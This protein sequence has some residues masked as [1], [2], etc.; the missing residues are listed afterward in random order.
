MS[1]AYCAPKSTTRTRSWSVTVLVTG[2][3]A[4]EA[5]R[6]EPSPSL[7]TGPV[8]AI[9]PHQPGRS[10]TTLLAHG[11]NP[12]RAVSASGTVASSGPASASRISTR[13]H[14]MTIEFAAATGRAHSFQRRT[15]VRV[16]LPGDPGYDAARMPWN[17]AVDQRPAAVAYP[18]TA[19]EVSEVVRAAAGRRPA[20]RARRAPATTPAR[21][22]RSSD[23]VL[24]RTSA[25]TGVARSTPSAGSPA[26]RP[27]CSG[28][29]SSRRPPPHGL[30]ALHGSSPDVGVVGYSLGG[31]IGWYARQLGMAT[32]SVTAVELV[33]GDGTQVRADARH[34]PRPVLGGPRRRRQLRR[35]HRDGVPA[36]RHRDGVR[37]DA[38]VGPGARREGAA[39]LGRVDRRPRRTASPRRSGC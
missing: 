2:P 25:M 33:L 13:R 12:G 22:A 29:T 20:G 19:D 34:Q 35:R 38:A 16:H 9:H 15:T 4:E 21:S 36:L 8:P 24:L 6:G 11:K 1:W 23:V 3:F 26:S 17:V 28:S 37:R 14:V 27:A 30:A 10:R 18:A 39:H 31:G 32:N 5:R 7:S